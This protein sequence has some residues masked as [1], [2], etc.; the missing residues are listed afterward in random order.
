MCEMIITSLRIY[1]QQ[2]IH[3]LCS[4]L[5]ESMAAELI[6]SCDEIDGGSSNPTWQYSGKIVGTEG[7]LQ[8]S[9][10]DNGDTCIC[11]DP[12]VALK[13]PSTSPYLMVNA[14]RSQ[15]CSELRTALF[16]K[17]VNQEAH[18]WHS[19]NTPLRKGNQKEVNEVGWPSKE[20]VFKTSP[21]IMRFYISS[22]HQDIHPWHPRLYRRIKLN[23]GANPE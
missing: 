10:E 4:A 19:Y 18:D 15:H 16:C 3:S 21:V 12:R 11:W 5:I 2:S 23:S 14:C 7:F 8:W 22:H 6:A 17:D 20:R 13:S 1:V 9:F